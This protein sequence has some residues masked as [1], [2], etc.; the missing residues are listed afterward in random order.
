ML[1]D[2][3]LN[4]FDKS[5]IPSDYKTDTN[6]ALFV[7]TLDRM[8]R[9]EPNP[10]A[11]FVTG[12]FRAHQWGQKARQARAGSDM[13]A[14]EDAMRRMAAAFDARFPR[15]QFVIVMGNNDDPCGDYRTAPG[16]PYLAR[17]AR[18]WAPLV[19]RGGAAPRF[20]EDFSATGAYV[21]RLPLPSLRAVAFDDVYWSIVYRGCRGRGVRDPG[22]VALQWMQ[23]G[24]DAGMRSIPVMHIP[25]G[26]DASST[27]IAHRF[28]TV[29]FLTGY[30][31][32]AFIRLIAQ[33]R[34]HIPFVLAGHLHRS[35]FRI[36]GNTPVLVAS[37]V[38]PIYNNNPGFLRLRVAQ[39]GTITDYQ[40][41]TYDEYS[42]EWDQAA[43]FDKAFGVRNFT[44]AALSALHDRIGRDPAVRARWIDWQL[45]GAR[46]DETRRN[47]RVF[48]CA[49]T[50]YG[51]G[52]AAC[53]GST[54]RTAVLPALAG[55][56]AAAMLLGV[57]LLVLRLIRHPHAR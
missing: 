51:S 17:L 2:I 34:S 21:A 39:D 55:L 31:S 10:P 43:D 27:I 49:Q 11:I 19:N 15:S 30:W 53:A 45:N 36:F 47:W 3:H 16:T 32:S 46:D 37:S 22:R 26:V 6:W 38:S 9:I 54:R 33:E 4:P 29:P 14:A 48:W 56:L 57:T 20:V 44:A 25:P 41:Y 18:I 28:L 5:P 50:E 1:S 24:N 40:Q 13:A 42:G 8:H 35:D 12:D 23:A 52:F 7:S